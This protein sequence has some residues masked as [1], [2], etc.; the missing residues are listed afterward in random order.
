MAHPDWA[1]KFRRP[2]TELRRV[3]DS[4]YKLYECSS[5]YDKEKKRARK[6][7]GKYLGSITE[8]GG[9]KE[10]RKRIMEREIAELKE[11]KSAV[12]AEPKIGEVK[13]FGL[14]DYILTEQSD[15]IDRLKQVFHED[16]SRIIALVYCRLRFQSP[17]RRVAGD[18]ADSYLSHKIGDRGLSANALSGFLHDLGTKRDKITEYMR[19]YID[20]L[21]NIIFDGT[22]Q[23]S[24][25]RCMDYPQLTKTKR[26]TF[27][28]AVNIMWIFNCAKHLPVYY[29]LM[30]GSIKDVSAF[31][32]C[33]ADSGIRDGVAIIDKGFQSASNIAQLDK[34]GIKFTMALKRSTKGL[35]YNIFASRTNDGADGAFL[36]HKKPIWWKRFEIDGHEVFL[37]LDEAHRSDESED[38]MR[39]VFDPEMEEYTMDGYK[40]KSLQFG[41]L[42]LMSTSGKDAEHVYLDYKTRGDVEQAIDAFK[43][44][45]EADHSYMQDEKSLEAWTFICMI[46]LQWYYDLSE[47]L[48]KAELSNR[49]AP[50]DMVRSLSRVRTV[51][52]ERKWIP[53]EVM[54]KD[55]QLVEAAGLDITPEQGI[56]SLFLLFRVSFPL[57]FPV[58]FLL[59]NQREGT[60]EL[61]RTRCRLGATTYALQFSNHVAYRHSFY[62]RAYSLQISVA[63]AIEL[64]VFDFA[65]FCLN[66]EGL[67]ASAFGAIRIF[68][69]NFVL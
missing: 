46:A 8:A 69:C 58:S 35:D 11:G 45:I 62:Q 23:L 36:Y 3:N 38:Y 2:G 41:T 7:T 52:V 59:H 20:P 42:A 22:D 12:I 48:K 4:L 24:A 53:A 32:V 29:R 37:Y 64:H 15:C 28:T 49:Y 63:A 21:D 67:T 55:R 31:K 50:M 26:G 47:R 33:L 9:F 66:V 5:V 60:A 65:V 39:R 34:L 18:F 57:F 16:W 14:S 27:D 25:S 61:I 44:V 43:N 54:K 51:R 17:M 19:S 68:H 30:P 56:L 1:V 13:E 40:V 6:I 10:S